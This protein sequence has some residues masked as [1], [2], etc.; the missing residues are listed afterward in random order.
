MEERGDKTERRGAG[1]H[2]CVAASVL[3]RETDSEKEV[4]IKMKAGEK[5]DELL[6]ICQSV[7]LTLPLTCYTSSIQAPSGSNVTSP[8]FTYHILTNT[9]I[10]VQSHKCMHALPDTQQPTAHTEHNLWTERR[11]FQGDKGPSITPI[12]VSRVWLL[13]LVDISL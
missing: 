9:P 11:H 13:G 2:A 3:Q 10:Y 12:K 5:N 4:G 1:D 7:T 6:G 8:S